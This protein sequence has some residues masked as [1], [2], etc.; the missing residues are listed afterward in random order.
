MLE[1]IGSWDV[2]EVLPT[3][4][5]PTLVMH[6]REDTFME[7]EHSRYLAQHIPDARYVELE[8]SA[9]T[10]SRS[11]TPRPSSGRWRSS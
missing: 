4:R 7:V 5:V 3:I 11:A 9:T 6:R 1:L 10:C 2:R 8:G